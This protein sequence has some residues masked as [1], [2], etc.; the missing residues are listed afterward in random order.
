MST[1]DGR[2]GGFSLPCGCARGAPTSPAVVAQ[3]ALGRRGQ[4]DAMFALEGLRVS[5]SGGC[6]AV[7]ARA[8]RRPTALRDRDG[9]PKSVYCSTGG[10][11]CATFAG[12]GATGELPGPR[13]CGPLDEQ[14]PRRVGG[15]APRGSRVGGHRG[16]GPHRDD[17][18]NGARRAPWSGGPCRWS[19]GAARALRSCAVGAAVRVTRRRKPSHLGR[20]VH[21]PAAPSRWVSA[22][23]AHAPEGRRASCPEWPGGS[24]AGS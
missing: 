4:S 19:A 1:P 21:R 20:G 22:R 14:R 23:G 17:D 2:P 15:Q 12:P 8:A 3:R 9:H 16:M 10:W 7:A 5:A 18:A 6:L 24:P 11:R 13:E